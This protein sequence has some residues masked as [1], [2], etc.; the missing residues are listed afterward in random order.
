MWLSNILRRDW[1]KIAR[2]VEA[3][4]DDLFSLLEDRLSGLTIKRSQISE[5]L[6]R[7]GLGVEKPETWDEKDFLKF[8]DVLR[9]ISK[10]MLIAANKIDIPTSKGNLQKLKTL[11]S[12][13]VPCCAE[14]ELAL[15]RAVDMLIGTR[16]PSELTMNMDWLTTGSPVSTVCLREQWLSQILALKTSQ[17]CLP[18]ASSF[19]MPV[20]F[21]AARLNDVIFH[22]ES[23]VKTPSAMLSSI[24]LV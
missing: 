16:S 7:T 24:I 8:V 6:R 9:Q 13:V 17:H 1:V 18:T 10:P 5:A 15:R 2:T 21:S 23:T 12:P 22:S 14:A 19:F 11:D 4:T 20:I 3:K